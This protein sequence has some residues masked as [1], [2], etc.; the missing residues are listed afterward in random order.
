MTSAFTSCSKE[1][2]SENPTFFAIKHYNKTVQERFEVIE[3]RTYEA[4]LEGFL[5]KLELEQ[6]IE[7]SCAF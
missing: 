6:K 3:E 7:S 4:N 1:I 2:M 5:C